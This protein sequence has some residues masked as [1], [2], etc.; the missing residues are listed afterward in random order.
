LLLSSFLRLLLLSFLL[1]HTAGFLLQVLS[2]LR[3]VIRYSTGRL[4]EVF[5]VCDGLRVLSSSEHHSLVSTLAF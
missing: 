5:I 2:R 3:G 1:C 4:F